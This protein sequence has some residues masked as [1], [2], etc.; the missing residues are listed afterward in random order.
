LSLPLPCSVSGTT[1]RCTT[2]VS[3]RV[4]LRANSTPRAAC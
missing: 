3:I 4:V 2:R 1:S